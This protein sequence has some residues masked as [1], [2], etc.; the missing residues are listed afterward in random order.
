MLDLVVIYGDMLILMG[1]GIEEVVKM[2]I[3]LVD[4]VGDFVLFKNIG[5]DCVNIVLNGVFIGEIEVLK[6]L[7]IVMI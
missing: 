6:G 2:F 3:L 1:I 5:I 7:G 4:L